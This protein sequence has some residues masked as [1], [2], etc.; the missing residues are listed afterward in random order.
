MAVSAAIMCLI[1][2]GC[3]DDDTSDGV[4]GSETA[5]TTAPSEARTA[6][7]V[8]APAAPSSAPAATGPAATATSAP[9]NDTASVN[10]GRVVA[11]GEE[12]L[13]ADLLALGVRPAASTATVPEAGFQGLDDFDTSGVEILPATELNL[14]RLAAVRPDT[15]VATEFVVEEAGAGVL[16]Q[17][18]DV[19]VVPDRL[20]SENQ[21]GVL[22]ERFGRTEEARTLIEDLQT[23]RR[24][25]RT[26]VAGGDCSVSMATIYPGPSVAAWVDG[27]TAIPATIID[28]GCP[29]V[30]GAGTGGTDD[31][32]RAFLSPEQLS[33][34]SA[35]TMVLLQ[36]DTVEGESDAVAALE[37]DPLWQQVPAVATGDVVTLDRLGYP[38]VTGQ[39]RLAR[40]LAGVLAP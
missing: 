37:R 27:P 33:L 21:L 38:G 15:I 20:S 4:A 30:P 26:A 25:L 32:G 1:A 9:V 18:A 6:T 29:L 11:L 3:G 10:A 35:P 12:F 13:L 39:V 24:S 34:L 17:L 16:D 28:A 36:S 5:T 40:D 23:A 31:N 19:V 22:G 8:A 7:A 2:T 14:E